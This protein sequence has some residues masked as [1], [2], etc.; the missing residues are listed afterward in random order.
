MQCL[1]CAF[2]QSQFVLCY[3][4]RNKYFGRG[5]ENLKR[6]HNFHT[7]T[8]STIGVCTLTGSTIGVYT[9]TVSISGVYTLTVSL[10]SIH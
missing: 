6:Y 4:T 9:L 8:G 5:D 7:L 1:P 10:V 3:S 2:L